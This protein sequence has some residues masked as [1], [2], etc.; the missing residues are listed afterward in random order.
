RDV[1]EGIALCQALARIGYETVVATPHIRT[2]MFNNRKAGL[3][4]AFAAFQQAAVGQPGMPNLGLGAEHYCDEVF[5]DLFAR[6]ETIPYP[7]GHAALI[8]MPPERLPLNLEAHFF[9]LSV[10]GVKPVIAHPERYTPLFK[11]SEGIETLV[12]HGALA[13]LDV[14]SLIGKYG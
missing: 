8:E 6:G 11:S 9:R 12:D 14:M 3:V 13:L 10:R 1:S 2:G 7:G 5:F 4:D